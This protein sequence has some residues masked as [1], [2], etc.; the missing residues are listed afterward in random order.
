MARRDD[1]EKLVEN[2]TGTFGGLDIIVANAVSRPDWSAT[3]I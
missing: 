3:V 1:C 2:A